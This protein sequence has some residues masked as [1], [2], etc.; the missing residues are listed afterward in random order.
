MDAAIALIAPGT[1]LREA[2]DDLIAAHAGAIIVV[3]DEGEVEAVCSGGF[4]I[5]IE[6]SPQRLF[7]LGK[8]DGAMILDADASRILR[9]NVHLIPDATLPT[10]ETG[11]RH[12]AAERVS[13]QT[14]A[15]VVSI[16]KRREVVHLYLDGRRVRIDPLHVVLA[17]ADQALQTLQRYRS[18]LDEDLVRLTAQEFDDLVVLADVAMVVRRFEMLSRVSVE[19][20]RHVLYLGR[21]GRLVRMQAEE[22]LQGA[23]EEFRAL[24]K[25]YAFDGAA[26][27]GHLRAALA[28]LPGA[29]LLEV[30]SIALALG[31][32]SPAAVTEEHLHA[33]GYR[34]LRR[35]PTLPAGVVARLVERFGGVPALVRADER[36]LD[37]VDGVGARRARAVADGLARLR[38]EAVARA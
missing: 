38:S 25:D 7:E 30:E 6:F 37:D 27:V 26:D 15:L 3:G 36:L 5:G 11:M 9:A 35:I 14:G 31:Y 8:M 17:K 4:R 22:L 21:E 23:D 24:L 10:S 1:P 19:I 28:E 12:R 33:R 20:G 16:S 18:R 2:I 29:S 34:L 32:P 13:R